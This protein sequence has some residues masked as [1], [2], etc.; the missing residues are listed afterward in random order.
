MILRRLV[1]SPRLHAVVTVAQRLPVA[2]VPEQLH[3]TP[4]GL[5][6]IHVRCLHVS[7]FLHALHAQRVL[8][9]VLLPGLLPSATVATAGSGPYLLRMQCF[10]FLTILLPRRDQRRAAGMPARD[11]WFCWHPSFLPSKAP[12]K[13]ARLIFNFR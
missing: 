11:L 13:V 12:R 3:V 1:L 8:L 4:V 2:P 6:V 9:K 5:Y 10:V 7:S